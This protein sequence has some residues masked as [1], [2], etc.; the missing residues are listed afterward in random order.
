MKREKKYTK[1][2]WKVERVTRDTYGTYFIKG[3]DKRRTDQ[4]LETED[5][6]NAF[7]ISSAPELL[8]ALESLMKGIGELPPI[9]AL[10]SV[11]EK[12]YQ[13]AEKAIAKAYGE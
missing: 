6:A 5:K 11:L 12:Q 10:Q 7:L 4:E 9:V 2:E 3:I 1:G 13:R 8:E